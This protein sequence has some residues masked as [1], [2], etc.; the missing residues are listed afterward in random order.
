MSIERDAGLVWFACDECGEES[1]E[2]DDFDE[3]RELA[4][5]DGW[6][7]ERAW[8]RVTRRYEWMHFCPDCAKGR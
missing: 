4:R 8:N 7:T 5:E 3:A 1:Q 2:G 6:R